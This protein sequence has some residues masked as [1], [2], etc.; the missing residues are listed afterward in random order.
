MKDVAGE[1]LL[2]LPWAIFAV[3]CSEPTSPSAVLILSAISFIA[4]AAQLVGQ[5]E[6]VL[7]VAHVAGRVEG[8]NAG[9]VGV[10]RAAVGA[11]LGDEVGDREAARIG[12]LVE[13]RFAGLVCLVDDLGDVSRV[14]AEGAALARV[15]AALHPE[16]DQ[17]QDQ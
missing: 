7:G 11:D 9:G 17:D 15:E 12:E 4:L 3:A 16:H 8:V 5:L 6:R 14:V 1:Q 10:H 2:H 13:Q